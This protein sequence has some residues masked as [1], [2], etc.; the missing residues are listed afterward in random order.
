[1]QMSLTGTLWPCTRTSTLQWVSSITICIADRGYNGSPLSAA[2]LSADW[3]S[4]W[5]CFNMD[6]ICFTDITGFKIQVSS[7]PLFRRITH[8]GLSRS[9]CVEMSLWIIIAAL[10]AIHS[11]NID[12]ACPGLVVKSRLLVHYVGS[13]SSE[14]ASETMPWYGDLKLINL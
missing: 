14:V 2:L 9:Y 7:Y 11:M 8:R 1:M 3:S 6:N 10:L 4:S 5:L 13:T 12:A